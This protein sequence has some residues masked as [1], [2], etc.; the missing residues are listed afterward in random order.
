MKKLLIFLLISLDSCGAY[1]H[2]YN[3]LK[4]PVGI[5]YCGLTDL[6]IYRDC[7]QKNYENYLRFETYLINDLKCID[8]VRKIKKVCNGKN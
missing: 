5:N 2:S 3:P 1:A 6:E 7:F 4:D 8:K